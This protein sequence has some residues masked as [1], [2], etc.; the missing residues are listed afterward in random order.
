MIVKVCLASILV[1]IL[2]ACVDKN[3]KSSIPDTFT[4]KKRELYTPFETLGIIQPSSYEEVLKEAFKRMSSGEKIPNINCEFKMDI[5]PDDSLSLTKYIVEELKGTIKTLPTPSNVK[6]MIGEDFSIIDL[7]GFIA[8]NNVAVTNFTLFHK[9]RFFGISIRAIAT[10]GKDAPGKK[11]WFIH[12][13]H[14]ANEDPSQIKG[15]EI[16]G[17]VTDCKVKGTILEEPVVPN[18]SNVTYPKSL[19][20]MLRTLQKQIEPRGKLTIPMGV[21]TRLVKELTEVTEPKAS[22]DQG[23]VVGN[24]PMSSKSFANADH[25]NMNLPSSSILT[26]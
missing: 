22:L 6:P 15:E 4:Q 16:K 10:R 23:K 5:D 12:L 19:E 14:Y 20:N 21:D 18:S 2:S 7:S 8:A 24:Q 11:P 9:K 17:N 1:C 13:I 3:I 26:K 25:R